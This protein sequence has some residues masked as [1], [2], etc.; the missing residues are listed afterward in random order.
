[1]KQFLLS[2]LSRKF[3]LAL[4]S[5]LV[6][7]ANGAYVEA[8]TVILGFLGVEG[9]SDFKSRSNQTDPIAQE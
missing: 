7:I 3:L 1:M 5:A 8:V 9:A 6:F 2:L 4:G